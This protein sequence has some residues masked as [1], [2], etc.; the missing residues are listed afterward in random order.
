MIIICIIYFWKGKGRKKKR[1]IPK[2]IQEEGEN[3]SI[4][5]LQKNYD[6]YNVIPDAYLVYEIDGK[7]YYL[8][9]RYAGQNKD[10]KMSYNLVLLD[11]QNKQNEFKV[12]LQDY[13]YLKKIHEKYGMYDDSMKEK[14]QEQVFAT[15]EYNANE[16]QYLELEI[17][18]EPFL[19]RL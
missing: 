16:E 9:W 13:H 14:F 8:T 2:I 10:D 15:S 12:H 7:E 1:R 19:K 3:E 4:P 5:F 11:Y 6:K 17:K 18:L